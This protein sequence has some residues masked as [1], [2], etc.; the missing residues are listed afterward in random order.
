VGRSALRSCRRILC[1]T[2]AIGFGPTKRDPGAQCVPLQKIHSAP[3][4]IAILL[5]RWRAL[6]AISIALPGV[7]PP[8]MPRQ[9]Y[10]YVFFLYIL[11]TDEVT[12]SLHV[13]MHPPGVY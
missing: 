9:M 2:L 6:C 13:I 1:V 12:F 10:T 4:V 3:P 7:A 11:Q 5:W 8:A